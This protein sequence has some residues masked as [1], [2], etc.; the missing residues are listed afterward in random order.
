MNKHDW[1]LNCIRV[2]YA[3]GRD[4]AAAAQRSTHVQEASFH[5]DDAANHTEQ[6]CAVTRATVHARSPTVPRL[7]SA[8]EELVAEAAR[9]VCVPTARTV[10]VSSPLGL[11]LL[12]CTDPGSLAFPTAGDSP[13]ATTQTASSLLLS[14]LPSLATLTTGWSIAR[15]PS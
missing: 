13:L 15:L 1:W 10:L 7:A 11:G 12:P 8:A 4:L 9:S 14:A 2:R 6:P 3:E 5:P